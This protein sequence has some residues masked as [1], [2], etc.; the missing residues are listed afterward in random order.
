ML[1]VISYVGLVICSVS[2]I[3]LVVMG[4]IAWSLQ[5][6]VFNLQK[7]IKYAEESGIYAQASEWIKKDLL[8]DP[9]ESIKQTN[10]QSIFRDARDTILSTIEFEPK[11]IDLHTQ[12]WGYITNTRELP[13]VILV[14]EIQSELLK[15]VDENKDVLASYDEIKRILIQ[16]FPE[17]IDIAN[18]LGQ[19]DLSTNLTKI[20]DVYHTYQ[21]GTIGVYVFILILL[22]VCILLTITLKNTSIWLGCLFLIS[23]LFIGVVG[24]TIHMLHPLLPW[25][26]ITQQL[27]IDIDRLISLVVS[28]ITEQLL[29]ISGLLLAVSLLLFI[30]R[31]W[32]P[33]QQQNPVSK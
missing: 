20:K 24:I 12:I 18:F 29:L 5:S 4:S 16:D 33:W 14:P 21:I 27:P 11:F 7:S 1:R 6:T 25:S 10:A 23:C 3:V 13:Q 9:I 30:T 2:F 28:D 15:A 22:I 32:K 8:G 19:Q 26:D 17:T 31:W